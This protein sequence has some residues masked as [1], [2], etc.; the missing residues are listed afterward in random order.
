MKNPWKNAKVGE[1]WLDGKVERRISG[2]V[3]E[4]FDTD[5]KDNWRLWTAAKRVENEGQPDEHVVEFRQD[6]PYVDAV[7]KWTRK[8]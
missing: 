2:V 7:A 3:A 8:E 5:G 6:M 4:G 1:V